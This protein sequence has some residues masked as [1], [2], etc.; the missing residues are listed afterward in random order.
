MSGNVWQVLP[1]VSGSRRRLLLGGT[2][3]RGW[4][5]PG[6]YAPG[7]GGGGGGAG[8]GVG[9]DVEGVS[10]SDDETRVIRNRRNRADLR[11]W[12]GGGGEAMRR[13]APTPPSE[14][15]TVA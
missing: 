10:G 15:A 13:R 3:P 8:A 5:H 14:A 4:P 6:L 2:V 11:G 7:A 1:C 9:A 12:R